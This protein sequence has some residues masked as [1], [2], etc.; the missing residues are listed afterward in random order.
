VGLFAYLFKWLHLLS[1]IGALGGIFTAWL[2]LAPAL[3]SGEEAESETAAAVWR[4]FGIAQGV[5]WLVILVTGFYNY[6]TIGPT[7]TGSYHMVAGMKIALAL[8][9]FLL[10][11]TAAH[12][13]PGMEGVKRVRA[14]L[15]LALAVL[16][17]LVV[18]LSVNLNMGRL[19]G[20]YLKPPA[21]AAPAGVPP[22]VGGAPAP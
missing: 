13:M 11:M 5:L 18:G 14:S 17:I 15:Y 2:V 3:R 12:P 22:P 10:A 4:R 9:M 16:G 21:A 1:V 8:L 19:S 6:F 7:A 20:K